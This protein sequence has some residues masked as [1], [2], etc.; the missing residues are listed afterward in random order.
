MSQVQRSAPKI[1][2]HV[3]LEGTVRPGLLAEIAQRHHSPLPER[4]E[5][6][7]RFRTLYEFIDTWNTLTRCLRSPSDYR[8][9]TLAYAAEAAAHGAVY[10]EPA[11]DAEERFGG[12]AG[13]ADILAACCDA[14]DEARE[15]FGVT[16]GWTPQIFRGY[17]VAMGE[18]AARVAT[19]FVGRGV[20]GFGLSGAEGRAATAPHARAVR[21]AQEGGLPFVPHAG[22]AAG[23]EAVRE[24]LALGAVR[25]RHGVRAVEDPDLVAE[26]ADRGI[27]L[28]VTLTSNVRLGVTPSLARHPLRTLLAAGVRCSVSTDDP[29]ILD[30][31][32]SDEYAVAEE[33]GL[34][35]GGA[36]AAGLAGALCDP[37]TRARLATV[38]ELAYGPTATWASP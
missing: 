17:D 34:S 33:L 2:L 15:R 32:L 16:I 18:E 11:L 35:A 24:V 14:A 10:L 31:T 38:G 5:H 8:L 9:I 7:Y 23:P 6:L 1:E 20:V 28:D 4:L 25:V 19:R 29:A 22:E 13:W 12:P 3:H 36:F 21:I 30:T 26:L 27:V 37:A